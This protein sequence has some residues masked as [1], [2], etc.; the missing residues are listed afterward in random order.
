[1]LV[2]DDEAQSPRARRFFESLS[3]E[4]QG[5]VSLVVLAEL[6]WVLTS[7]YR[8]G[9]KELADVIEKLL[10]TEQLA[11]QDSPAVHT[12]L[13]AY[14]DG[15]DFADAL[16]DGLARSAGCAKTVTFDRRAA[17]APGMELLA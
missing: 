4:R 15:A 1:M 10:E 8:V 2:A 14:R 16:I 9:R 5:Y 12:A 6:F 11:F 7:R 17:D 3:V 13:L